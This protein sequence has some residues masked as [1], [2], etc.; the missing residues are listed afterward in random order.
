MFSI[1]DKD[2]KKVKVYWFVHFHVTSKPFGGTY[3]VEKF[4]TDFV[5]KVN[6]RLGYKEE[7][8]L[9]TFMLQIF[10]DLL[11]SDELT[12]QVARHT[13]YTDEERKYLK[14]IR[15]V[16]IGSVKY[17]MIRKMLI[18]ESNLTTL[19]KYAVSGKYRIRSIAGS[20]ERWYGLETSS[21]IIEYVPLFIESKPVST[22]LKRRH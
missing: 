10:N 8:R 22:P 6:I 16:N 18:P 15:P 17:C 13:T 14:I 12:P 3:S 2:P 9:S 20:P 21:V 4:D 7:Q 19:D 11:S 1:L 5:Y